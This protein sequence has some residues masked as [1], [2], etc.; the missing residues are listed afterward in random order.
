MRLDR[1]TASRSDGGASLVMVLV[2][3]MVVGIAL[4]ALLPY[5]QAGISEAATARDV[6]TV[7]NAVDGAVTGAIAAARSSLDEGGAASGLCDT[8]NAPSY[9]APV[10][11]SAVDVSVAC[12]TVGTVTPG[13]VDVP[14]YAIVTTTAGLSVTG[15]SALSVNGGIYASGD[16]TTNSAQTKLVVNGDVWSTTGNCSHVFAQP[17]NCPSTG[18]PSLPAVDQY[19]SSLGALSAT[20]A[21]A[22]IANLRKD[23][24]GTCASN[25]SI[26]T[27]VPGYYSEQPATDSSCASNNSSIW[28]FA[29]CDV[30]STPSCTSDT[31]APGTYYFDFPD[32]SYNNYDDSGG[33]TSGPGALWNLNQA[34]ISV[35]GGT[36]ASPWGRTTGWTTVNSG[37]PGNRCDPTGKGV[38]FVVGGPTHI[39]T[40]NGSE[41][42]LCGSPT[43]TTSGDDYALQ[44]IVLYGLSH[45]YGLPSPV[46]PRTAASPNPNAA[47]DDPAADSA[48]DL[49]FTNNDG[50]RTAND[51]LNYATASFLGIGARTYG[52]KLTNF[53]KTASNGSLPVQMGSHIGGAWI[54]VTHLETSN[55]LQPT[56]KIAYSNGA[57]DTCSVNSTNTTIP[58]PATQGMFVTD[59]VD[60]MTCG[61]KTL[62][63]S[64]L[65]WKLLD[66]DITDPTSKP[67]TV[68][69]EVS[70]G[71][72]T[73]GTAAVD[74]VQLET[75]SYAPALEAE[76]CVSGAAAT[77]SP[78]A[79]DNTQSTASDNTY[80]IGSY[81]TPS[82][83]LSA[84][85]HNSPNT[86]FSR[87]VVVSALSVKAN[88]SSTQPDPPFQLPHTSTVSRLVLFT[89]T[90]Q[91]RVRLR[92]LVQ[93]IDCFP[94][95]TCASAGHTNDSGNLVW[96]GRAVVIKEWTTVNN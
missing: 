94:A 28:W 58:T 65:R 92:A 35:V 84:V 42:E 44:R 69:Y 4:S 53:A 71:N 61:S 22:A 3:V 41:I 16:I 9:P 29:P 17:I 36:L 88:A 51:G 43:S 8:Y 77:C 63:S 60:L 11:S 46:G 76:R 85:V 31:T 40:G 34:N 78:S 49:P 52:V 39:S 25:A 68:T 27:F 75:K 33:P 6:R 86:I 26:V 50:A 21:A 79:Y 62:A 45:T 87:G 23:P 7:Q 56:I 1:D 12:Q 67:L 47:A 30:V 80:F 5:T 18:V 24:P 32:G 2:F 48:P 19:P 37:T 73:V 57:S 72:N 91:G 83:R 70:G 54:D 14:P 81:Y 74:G 89:A 59:R 82:A 20:A 96:P 90:T 95:G 15:N 13:Q 66:Q 55:Q 93:Y 10:G 38:Q 64:P